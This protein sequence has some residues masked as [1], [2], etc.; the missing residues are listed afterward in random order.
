MDLIDSLRQFRIGPFAIF[1]FIAT[2]IA[3]CYLSSNG[4][5]A[6]ECPTAFL[7]LIGI[8]IATHFIMGIETPLNKAII[9]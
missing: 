4:F 7:Q 8:G 9:G 5:L 6:S 3:A 2:F 1:D